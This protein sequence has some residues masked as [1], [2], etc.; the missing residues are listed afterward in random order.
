MYTPTGSQTATPIQV[1]ITVWVYFDVTPLLDKLLKPVKK[2]NSSVE[3]KVK[4]V[5][6]KEYG[7][8]GRDFL[9]LFEVCLDC[10]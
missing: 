1:N 2:N 9:N 4:E 8:E 3:R 7:S 5:F 10:C 6:E